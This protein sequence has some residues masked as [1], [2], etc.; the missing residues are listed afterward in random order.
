MSGPSSGRV[1]INHVR[2]RGG[3]QLAWTA[4][5]RGTPSILAVAAWVS[6]LTRDWE[7]NPIG[8]FYRRLAGSHRLIRYDRPG[9][10]MST[11]GQPSDHSLEGQ[12]ADILSVLDA[13]GERRV[14]VLGRSI[15][16]PAALALAA[17][18]PERVSHLVLFGTATTMMPDGPAGVDRRLAGAVA[19][20]IEA[21]WGLAAKTIA[22]MMLPDLDPALVDWY[23]TYSRDAASPESVLELITAHR[24]ID[25]LPL[26]ARIR[27]PTLIVHNRHDRT[28]PLAR[29]QALADAIRGSRLVVLEGASNLPFFAP[30][31]LL[32]RLLDFVNPAG[33]Q[34]TQREQSV[35][36][37]VAAGLSNLEAGESLGVSAHTVARH[38]AN[39]YQKL[40]VH[41]RSAA[42]A[43]ARLL[44]H[45]EH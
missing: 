18:H 9:M 22:A 41:S 44:G 15:G 24:S 5:G 35:L 1:S 28:V 26:V 36:Q 37:A 3:S 39:V 12:V 29:A 30:D 17:L 14:A 25:V 11:T 43:R 31:P 2:S 34:L 7:A 13:A 21:D 19:Q 20:L 4:A 33:A 6:H 23:A 45:L 16:G 40:G 32:A 42:V 10:G 38:L 27:A 8:D